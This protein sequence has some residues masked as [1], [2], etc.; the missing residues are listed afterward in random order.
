VIEI[1]E[2]KI[3]TALRNVLLKDKPVN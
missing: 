3:D 2:I 1:G